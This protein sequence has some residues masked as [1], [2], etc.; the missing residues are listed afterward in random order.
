MI[1]TD[2]SAY[3]FADEAINLFLEY[4]DV[5]GYNEKDAQAAAARDTQDGIDAEIE[6][7][8]LGE[9]K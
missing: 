4:R 7:R 1:E 8:A 9:I 5:H 2:M 6:L 3:R